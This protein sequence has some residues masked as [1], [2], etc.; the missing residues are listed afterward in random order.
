MRPKGVVAHDTTLYAYNIDFMQMY[1]EY[2]IKKKLCSADTQHC[3]DYIHALHVVATTHGHLGN[4]GL[5]WGVH[6][7]SKWAFQPLLE[8]LG[9]WD[10]SPHPTT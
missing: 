7:C 9:W 8:A 6:G 10:G 2:R 1:T 5:A 4:H 3:L